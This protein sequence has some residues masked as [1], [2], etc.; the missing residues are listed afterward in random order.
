MRIIEST[1]S[2]Q[3]AAKTTAPSRSESG[4]QRDAWSL[5]GWLGI[6]FAV[7]AFA[8][9]GLGIYPLAFGNL[10][11]E[12]GMISGVLNGFA[13]P[14]MAVYLLLGSLVAQGKRV[15]MRVMASVMM[16]IALLLVLLG[17]LYAT[18]IPLALKSVSS[19]AVIALGMKK[20]IVKAGVLLVGYIALY[21]FGAFRGWRSGRVN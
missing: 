12:F 7:L 19:N 1:P 8:D 15:G 14:T 6:V 5:L 21:V 18:A 17:L 9:I 11:W 13:I 3:F 20:A 2:R 4:L 16:L 10:E